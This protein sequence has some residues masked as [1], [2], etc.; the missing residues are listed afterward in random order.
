MWRRLA[1]GID[2]TNVLAS[3]VASRLHSPNIKALRV[4]RRTRQAGL[5]RHERLHR[6]RSM[7][8]S[9]RAA[10]QL[11]GHGVLVVDDIRTT[12]ATLIEACSVVREAGA[13]F[14]V[15]A[16]ICV[17]DMTPVSMKRSEVFASECG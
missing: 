14:I 11:S 17:A 2:H 5:D 7:H 9:Q 12:G 3:A 10:I 13:E 8:C 4:G 15:P 1:R 6:A 16:V